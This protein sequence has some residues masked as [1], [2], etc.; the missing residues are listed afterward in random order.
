MTDYDVINRC[1]IPQDIEPTGTPMIHD[2]FRVPCIV[3]ADATG[4]E[5]IVKQILATKPPHR[6]HF[7]DMSFFQASAFPHVATCRELNTPGWEDAACVHFSASATRM[8]NATNAGGRRREWLIRQLMF[9]L[10]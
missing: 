7:S 1:L 8:W 4:A 5:E 6:Q 3:S 10:P 2:A 9:P